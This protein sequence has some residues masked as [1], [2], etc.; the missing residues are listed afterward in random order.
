MLG[1]A[2]DLRSTIKDARELDGWFRD[3]PS[4][5]IESVQFQMVSTTISGVL[6]HVLI[7]YKE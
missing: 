3:N 7:I 5:T 6:P 2:N 1:K 4:Y